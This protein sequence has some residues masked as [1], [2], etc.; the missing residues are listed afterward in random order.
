M[1]FHRCRCAGPERRSGARPFRQITAALGLAIGLAS[2][3][4]LTTAPALAQGRI[5]K[6]KALAESAGESLVQLLV[7]VDKA[8]TVGCDHEFIEVLVANP[9][10]A[11]VIALSSKQVYVLGK[12]AGITSISLVGTNKKVIGLV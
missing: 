8:K 11:D 5:Q 10:I 7:T 2:L 1:A 4:A 3:A 6:N 9:T 12:K